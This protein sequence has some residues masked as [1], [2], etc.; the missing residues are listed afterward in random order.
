[1]GTRFGLSDSILSIL[2]EPLIVWRAAK[3]IPAASPKERLANSVRMDQLDI[4]FSR[5]Q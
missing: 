2:I 1:M 4:Y 3:P 5:D